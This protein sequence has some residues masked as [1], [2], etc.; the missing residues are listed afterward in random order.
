[1]TERKGQGRVINLKALLA[2]VGAA[3]QEVLEAEIAYRGKAKI[4]GQKVK[5]VIETHTCQATGSLTR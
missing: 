4:Y 3:L 5:G 2:G 1:M